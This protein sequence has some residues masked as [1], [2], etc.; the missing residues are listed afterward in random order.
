MMV[1]VL[2]VK[3]HKHH[4]ESESLEGLK[5]LFEEHMHIY[6]YMAIT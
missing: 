6:I 1:R 5:K 4:E 3:R 2:A